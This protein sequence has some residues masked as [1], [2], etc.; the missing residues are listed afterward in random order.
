MCE[1]RLTIVSVRD[2]RNLYNSAVKNNDLISNNLKI[3]TKKMLSNHK[4]GMLKLLH[5]MYLSD[6]VQILPQT[7]FKTFTADK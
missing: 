6:I 5:L 1:K 3:S 7:N 4:R 2:Y